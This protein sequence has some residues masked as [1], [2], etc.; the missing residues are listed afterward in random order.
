MTHLRYAP[1]SLILFV[2]LITCSSAGAWTL[3][4]PFEDAHASYLGENK[5]DYSATA[6]GAG[7]L[8]ADGHDDL[9]IGSQDNDEGGEDAGQVYVVLGKGA[10]W[11]VDVVL[12]QADASF[13]GEAAGDGLGRQL[14]AVGD[15]DGDGRHDLL[16]GSPYNEEG[17]TGAGQL[18]LV[19]GHDSGWQRDLDV[20]SAAAGSFLGTPGGSIGGSVAGVGDVNGDGLDD[21]MIGRQYPYEAI[22]VLGATSGWTMDQD[23]QQAASGSFIG[24]DDHLLVVAGAGDVDGDGYDD[25]LLGDSWDYGESHWGKVYLIRGSSTGWTLGMDPS[26]ADTVFMAEEQGDSAGSCLASAGDV[27]GDGLDDFLI[28]APHFGEGNQ[29]PG[30]AYLILGNAGNWPAEWDLADAH[31][32]FLGMQEQDYLSNDLAALGDLDGDGYDD[33]MIGAPYNDDFGS[34]SGQAY[35]FYGKPDGW[36]QN[37]DAVDADA[38]FAGVQG[39]GTSGINLSGP[40][41]LDGNGLYDIVIGS[42]GH[43][44]QETAAG[45]TYIFFH[46]PGTCDDADGDGYGVPGSTDCGGGVEQDCD[47]EDPAVHPGAV[48][49]CD[50]GIDND[51]DGVIDAMD[52]DCVPDEVD[53]LDDDAS[54]DPGGD[55]GNGCECRAGSRTSAAPVLTIGVLITGLLVTRRRIH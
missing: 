17:G 22:L 21:L 8:D 2:A 36:G 29:D 19:L 11:A 23:I 10:G 27:N 46:D 38:S 30:K 37:L 6:I 35:L 39:D 51:C 45:K 15:V 47:D 18:Y 5:W 55:G 24:D 42:R 49:N 7:D 9:V 1:L 48:E 44:Q 33:F 3:D 50:D 43:S 25:V 52:P 16:L 12:S 34:G 41:D 20:G 13:L 53:Y 31:A 28:G 40:T 14:A 4:T 26:A 54:A 32:S